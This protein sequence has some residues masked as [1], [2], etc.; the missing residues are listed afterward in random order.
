LGSGTGPVSHSLDDPSPGA[1]SAEQPPPFAPIATTLNRPKPATARIRPMIASSR[2]ASA[3]LAGTIALG[4]PTGVQALRS[5]FPVW[6]GWTST[7]IHEPAAPRSHA[8]V[9]GT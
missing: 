6:T 5:T 2:G 9:F 1:Y 8:I 7:E 4:V 3:A